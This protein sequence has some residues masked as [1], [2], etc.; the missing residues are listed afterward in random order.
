MHIKLV[1]PLVQN[2]PRGWG[3]WKGGGRAVKVSCCRVTLCGEVSKDRLR[4]SLK[5][6]VWGVAQEKGEP[7]VIQNGSRGPVLISN[8]SNGYAGSNGHAVTSGTESASPNVV[9]S[10]L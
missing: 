1:R 2:L 8:G 4:L 7:I 3:G 6:L 9:P 10:A 5:G